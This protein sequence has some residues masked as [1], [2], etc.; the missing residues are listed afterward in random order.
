[1]AAMKPVVILLSTGKTLHPALTEDARTK[2]AEWFRTSQPQATTVVK[3]DDLY[4]HLQKA[5]VA[6]IGFPD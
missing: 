3:V 4:V 5:H 6:S 1:M 2:L